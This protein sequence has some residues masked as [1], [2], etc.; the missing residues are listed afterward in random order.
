[1][2]EVNGQS[3]L[4]KTVLGGVLAFPR[5]FDDLGLFEQLFTDFSAIQVFKAIQSLR[6]KGQDVDV[7]LLA[8]VLSS[9]DLVY[10]HECLSYAP[11]VDSAVG[12]HCE[13]LKGVW[14]KRKLSLAGQQLVLD[15]DTPELSTTEVISRVLSEIDFVSGSSAQ[16]EV[17]YP[18]SFLDE[19]VEKM[20]VKQAF[21]PTCWRRL[22]KL[23]G[24][25]R[26]SGFYIVA[27]RPGQGK[28]IVLLQAAFELAKT[29]KHVL[30]FSLEMPEIQLQHRLLA[31]ALSLDVASIAN[32]DLDYPVVNSDGSKVSARSLVEGAY[33]S[34]TNNLGLVSA[35]RLTP[36][37]LRSYISAASKRDK[38]DAVFIDYLGLMDDDVSHRDRIAKIGSISNQLK[39]IALELDIPVVAAV[40]LN[41]DVEHRADNKP[42]LSDLRDSGSIEQDA[43][44]ILMIGRKQREGDNPD[45]YGSEFYLR[46][47]KNRH[48]AM[49]AAKFVAQDAYSRIVEE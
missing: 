9:S 14:A 26:D 36:A 19:Y 28:T 3:L 42:Q 25:W 32:N 16:L 37:M 48:G 20:R 8:P 41:R 4:E 24:G 17:V 34:L 6:G 27:G 49:G 35:P 18:S 12:W 10:A 33:M 23:V 39:R 44:V 22:N 15:V 1:M 43:D 7:M 38:V 46:V 31:Q 30:Y 11:I 45:A 47:A 21:M 29:G 2:I 13:A 40:Q 5:V